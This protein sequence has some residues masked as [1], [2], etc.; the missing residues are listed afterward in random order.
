[1]YNGRSYR[2]YFMYLLHVF[3]HVMIKIRPLFF[4]TGRLP[5][6]NPAWVLTTAK[7]AGANGLTSLLKHGGARD[8]TFW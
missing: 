5:D 4:T 6:V 8:N 3:H 7:A 2:M 1:M